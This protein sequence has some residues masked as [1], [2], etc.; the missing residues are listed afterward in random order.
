MSLYLFSKVRFKI[1]KLEV[2][3]FIKIAHLALF[4]TLYHMTPFFKR[5]CKNGPCKNITVFAS[6]GD[7][8]FVR[9]TKLSVNLAHEDEIFPEKERKNI[10]LFQGRAQY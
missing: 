8:H 4:E 5:S 6:R 2:G 9:C 7:D 3:R 10:R 1:R